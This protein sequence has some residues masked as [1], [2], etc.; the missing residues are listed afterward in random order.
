MLCNDTGVLPGSNYYFGPVSL[1]SDFHYNIT[2]CGSFFC[3]YGY[4][5][6]RLYYD[7]LLL[8]YIVEGEFYITYHETDY[9]AHT[10]D[11]VLIDC[12]FPHRWTKHFHL[13]G[14]DAEKYPF[15]TMKAF[16]VFI[17][18]CIV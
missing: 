1:T 2:Q 11:A 14:I 3:E 17:N 12:R 10:E 4:Q 8:A 16:H 5:I 15:F 13:Q 6:D 9:T 18:A 7:A